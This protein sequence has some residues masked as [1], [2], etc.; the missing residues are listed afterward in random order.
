MGSRGM[1]TMLLS[2][3]F[4][5]LAST[6]AQDDC[7]ANANSPSCDDPVEE[8]ICQL[9]C[10]R[11]SGE[12]CAQSDE[13]KCG[14]IGVD[15]ASE[16]FPDMYPTRCKEIC[17][18]SREAGSPGSICRFYKVSNYGNEVVCSLMNDE[19]CTATGPCGSHCVSGD[20]GCKDT[21]IP[22]PHD[23]PAEFEYTDSAFHFG[24]DH[25]NPYS[26]Q[27]CEEGNK[28]FTTERCSE[29]DAAGIDPT[30]P[31]WRKLAIECTRFGTWARLDNSGG[32]DEDYVDVLHDN[33]APTEP[34]CKPKPIE[35]LPAVLTEEGA[36]FLC[37]N[38]LTMNEDGTHL[39][40]VAPNT[41]V[42]LC[43]FHL[44]MSLECQIS[45]EGETKC[46]DEGDSNPTSA[47]NIYCWVPPT[48]G[49]APPV[50]NTTNDPTTPADDPTTPA[51][52][53]EATTPE[54]TTPA[55]GL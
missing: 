33:A 35:I 5:L 26:D 42:L 54:A 19:Q 45:E 23:C 36:D 4:C 16:T 3:I 11:D 31:Y 20:V 14:Q 29:W 44:S 48:E 27:T 47:D 22:G 30:S 13:A 28:C 53:P 12:V 50:T 52:D 8:T 25:C 43:D 41:C 51:D 15:V 55:A 7:P 37:D 1:M 38:E 39:E 24:C 10:D 32:S 40:I 9:T 6:L 17:E 21:P 49:T 18:A 34:N 46:Y 2:V